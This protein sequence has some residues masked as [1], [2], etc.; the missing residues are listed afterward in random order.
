MASIIRSSG[1]QYRVK[2]GSILT[3]DRLRVAIGES[4]KFDDLLGGASIVAT[5][6]DH[7]LGDKVNTLRFRNKTRYSRKIGHRQPKTVLAFSSTGAENTNE[8]SS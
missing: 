1:K 7:I 6:T 5:V 8:A 4:I 2:P 3:V